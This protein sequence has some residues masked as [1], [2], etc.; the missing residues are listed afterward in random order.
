MNNYTEY[1]YA[2]GKDNYHGKKNHAARPAPASEPGHRS[3]S[4]DKP[5]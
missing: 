1:Y 4:R 5:N 2:S 3:R